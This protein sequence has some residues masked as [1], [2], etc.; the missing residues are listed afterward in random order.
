LGTKGDK[1][2]FNVAQKMIIGYLLQTRIIEMIGNQLKTLAN[3]LKLLSTSKRL[4]SA[5]IGKSPPLGPM[6]NL[7]LLIGQRVKQTRKL[8]YFQYQILK[9][10]YCRTE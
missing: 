6:Q 2:Q 5:P 8:L 4:F 7:K 9:K 10:R 1:L 3:A